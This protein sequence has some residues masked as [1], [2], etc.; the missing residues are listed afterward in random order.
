MTDEAQTDLLTET[1]QTETTSWHSAENAEVVKRCGWSNANDVIKGYRNLEISASGKTKIP[2]DD[3]T[4]DEVSAFYKQTG[5]PDTPEGYT[6]P[7]L[8]EGQEM[9]KE[10]F[11]GWATIAH[12]SGMSDAQF[13]SL[14]KKYVE[15]EAQQKEAEIVE[16][17]R[18]KEE[19]DR[20]LH[21]TYGADYDKNIELSKRAYTEYANEELKA[22][23][24]TDKFI[25]LRNEPSF[26]NMMVEIG[27][28]NMNDTFVLSDSQ[29]ESK[30]DDFVPS[31]LNSPDM[32]A[33]MD[34]EIGAKSRA[35]FR[36][37]RNFVYDRKD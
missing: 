5:R 28:K 16:F 31:S 14:A 2:T 9:D 36:R 25:G 15:L 10:V 33:N 3:S 6:L 35:Y 23:L 4:P 13:T 37:T 32:Y 1:S 12:E 21:E 11:S 7:A 30:K 17:N 18:Y 8:G 29:V 19:S 20:K 24:D 22:L 27:K 26:I 34:G